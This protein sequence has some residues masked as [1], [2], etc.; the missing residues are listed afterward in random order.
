MELETIKH[1]GYTIKI[2]QDECP[3]ESPRDWDNLGTM[4]CWHRNYSLGDK[5]DFKELVA[6]WVDLCGNESIQEEFY[7]HDWLNDEQK[8]RA[9]K[10]AYQ[11]N[12]ILPLYL[13]DHSGITMRTSPFSCRWD[14]GQVGYIYISHDKIR[15]EYGWKKL[16]KARLEKI[17][18][19]LIGEVE[20]Y[21]NY[22]TG[23]VY[24][25][26]I[27]DRNGEEIDSCWGFYG[28]DHEAS[29]LMENA[30]NAVDCN[31]QNN[32]NQ[33]IEKLKGWI[34]NQVALHYREP[35]HV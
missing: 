2:E 14:S 35:C 20:T 22:L 5:H 6:L 13:Y 34:R 23:S 16:T 33:H 25:Y 10:L 3:A 11:N 26:V 8:E 24:G 1:R 21:D 18:Q 9:I 29:G 19:Y 7:Y 30:Q 15:K 28:Y 4:T 32:I 27:E 31:I 12:V 17:K